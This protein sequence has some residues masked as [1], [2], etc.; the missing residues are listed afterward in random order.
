[1]FD[2]RHQLLFIL[3]SVGALIPTQALG[4]PQGASLA[5]YGWPTVS[6]WQATRATPDLALGGDPVVARQ[7]CPPLTRFNL[8]ANKGEE[9]LLK[10]IAEEFRSSAGAFWRL[11]LR[12]G[13]FWW[14]GDAVRNEDLAAYIRSILADVVRQKAGGSWEI[15]PFEVKTEGEQFV[16]VKWRHP[17]VFGPF[18][19]N[20]AP[21]F[22]TRQAVSANS[23]LPAYE[24]V[25]LYKL[26]QRPFGVELQPSPAYQ[27]RRPL[28]TIKLFATAQPIQS[29]GTEP[30]LQFQTAD[31]FGGNPATRTS[32]TSAGCDRIIA[33]PLTTFIA[34][35]TVQGPTADSR[36]RQVLTQITPRGVLAISA[37]AGLAEIATAPI[38]RDHPGYDTTLSPRPFDIDGAGAV[39]DR[40]GYR[41]PA[42][43]LPRQGLSG[44]PLRLIILAPDGAP[45]LVGKVV[46]DAYASVGIEVLFKRAPEAEEIPSGVLGAYLLDWPGA[47]LLPSLHSHAVATTP[48]WSPKDSQ[49]DRVLDEW[50]RSLTNAVPDAKRLAAVHKRVYEL[51]P[52]TV[53]LQHKT[54]LK[55]GGGLSLGPRRFEARDPD[56]FRQLV[57]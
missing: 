5:V 29:D 41:R 53:I 49:L 52:A 11:E 28:P 54:C 45:G 26:A 32:D 34:W 8:G 40:L 24:C 2:V 6:A 18:V 43:A 27:T 39:L 20:D 33:L 19:F 57:L 17:P 23:D 38:P 55:A 56:W 10:R 37:A 14:N 16:T 15:P 12:S 50:G 42:P 25:G 21:F 22:R 36:L 47:S 46:V 30:S 9:V 35:N 51:E 48:F 4:A 44:D 1:M 31:A 3:A 7:A 13:L